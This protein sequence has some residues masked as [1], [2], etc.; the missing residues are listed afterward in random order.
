M[1]FWDE[2][3][4][5][6]EEFTPA[7]NIQKKWMQ[8]TVKDLLLGNFNNNLMGDYKF[9]VLAWVICNFSKKFNSYH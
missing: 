1:D 3:V 2:D 4:G 5:V 8:V 6:D 9:N 7:S